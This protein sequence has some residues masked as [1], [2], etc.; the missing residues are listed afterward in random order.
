MRSS[1]FAVFC[2]NFAV[3]ILRRDLYYVLVVV[4]GRRDAQTRRWV[5]Q[6]ISSTPNCAR[7]FNVLTIRYHTC[8]HFIE[9]TTAPKTPKLKTR[10]S[11]A[12]ETAFADVWKQRKGIEI[13]NKRCSIGNMNTVWII[14][15]KTGRFHLHFEMRPITAERC[16][17][18]FI[19]IRRT[20]WLIDLWYLRLPN[21][22]FANTICHF[23]T[24]VGGFVR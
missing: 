1:S 9:H 17:R 18:W 7:L 15:Y 10:V 13:S 22:R 21:L 11:I 2:A 19:H 5:T 12:S 3:K 14:D 8:S 20:L 23:R 6:Q 24:V 16:V 4:V